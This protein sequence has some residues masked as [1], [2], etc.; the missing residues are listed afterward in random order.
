M[1]LHLA[2][3]N[4][5]SSTGRLLPCRTV[6][7]DHVV[8]NNF[9]FMKGDILYT[10]LRP[11]LN[12][13]VVAPFEGLCSSD[14]LPIRA[15][16]DAQFLRYWML[17]P[18]FVG[19]AIRGQTGVTLPRISRKALTDIAVP[20]APLPEQRRI[21]EAIETRFTRL[22]AAVK[23]LQRVR[24]N[25]KRYRASVW[26]AASGGYFSSRVDR[27]PCVGIF[28]VA[29]DLDGDRIP[30][31]ATDREH[32]KGNV[33]YYGATGQVG[34]IDKPIFNEELVLLGEDGVDFL[35]RLKPKAYTIRGPAWVNNHAHV[36]RAKPGKMLTKFLEVQLNAANYFGLANGTTRLKLTKSAMKRIPIRAPPV[37]EQ[38]KIIEEID[39]RLSIVGKVARSA[40]GGIA[41][42]ARA[43]ASVLQQAFEGRL[44]VQEPQD[45]PA[46]ALLERIKRERSQQAPN[47]P[48]GRRGRRRTDNRGDS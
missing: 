32:R 15:R 45:E 20:V 29:D 42:C 3:D 7:E 5:E 6:A 30:V 43:R 26:K 47:G 16:I 28:D 8:S 19:Q 4:I 39:C 12:K 10:R 11:Y 22:D 38:E 36:L 24:A 44:V 21:V 34:W 41:R 23:A 25:L 48:S 35:D 27:W 37:A 9:Q 2:P 13:V 18:G 1:A 46:S 17:S 33:P 40:E 14:V 31:N